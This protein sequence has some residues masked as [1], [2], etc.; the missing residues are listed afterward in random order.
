MNPGE[1]R[2]RITILY[3]A[4]PDRTD[5]NGNSWPDWQP[6]TDKPIWAKR[7]GLKGR[8]FFQAAAAQAEDDMLFTIRYRS[9]VKAKMQIVEGSETFDIYL[10]PID[11]DGRK[12][13]LDI[14]AKAVL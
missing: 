5:D 1:L 4:Q 10:P 3:N 14:H 6:L 13:W 8:M 9:D 11:A 12:C 2:H 7:T